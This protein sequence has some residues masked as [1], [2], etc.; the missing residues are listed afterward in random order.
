MPCCIECCCCTSLSRH[1]R[2]V[3]ESLV[4]TIA[5]FSAQIHIPESIPYS[6]YRPDS[7]HRLVAYRTTFLPRDLYLILESRSSPPW[8]SSPSSRPLF[9]LLCLFFFLARKVF[10]AVKRVAKSYS[11][12]HSS[13]LLFF[14]TRKIIITRLDLLDYLAC[15]GSEPLS[16]SSNRPLSYL[17]VSSR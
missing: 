13:I 7:P 15:H 4:W 2:G 8:A 17:L 3:I 11:A 9:F 12:L 10:S 14:Y 6:I 16:L 1:S 5:S